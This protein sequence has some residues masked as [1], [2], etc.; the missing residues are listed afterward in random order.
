MIEIRIPKLGLTMENAVV[1]GW[2]VDEGAEVCHD[3]LLLTIETDKLTFDIP[4][5]A[6]GI[7]MRTAAQGDVCT[8][9]A[10]VGY[11]AGDREEY[12]RLRRRLPP[13]ATVPATAV[14][15]APLGMGALSAPR[16]AGG[17]IKASPLARAV[18]AERGLD[19]SRIEG[20]G[21][22]GRIVR[23]DILR[24]ADA[25]LPASGV[26]PSAD[27]DTRPV[28]RRI[29]ITGARRLLFESMH[30]SMADT[31]QFSLHTD[32]DAGALQD[33]R[34]RLKDEGLQISYNAMLIKITAAA[35]RKHP[36][37]NAGVV[38]GN[39]ILV[40][41]NVNIG[42]AMHIDGVLVVPVFRSADALSLRQINTRINACMRR[43]KR[44][45]LSPDELT[46]G[47]FTITN[48]GF[49]DVDH[50]T[51]I[52]RPPESAVLGVGRIVEKPVAAQGRIVVR[53]MVGL[54]LTVDHRIIDG[55]PAARF[56]HTLKQMLENPD[57][58]LQDSDVA[59]L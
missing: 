28:L 32:A 5:P 25:R 20:S 33:L 24:S 50:F 37:I 14:G 56:L 10:V 31:A 16:T 11:L 46:G 26:Q 4:A 12:R 9:E 40:W 17:R 36:D 51:P 59:D 45:R 29:P 30:R 2:H 7:L 38:W 55:A 21:P 57:A 41:K 6:G 53:P 22:G 54:S 58:V 3:D 49:T 23:A 1:A 13:S 34:G 8:V 42:L 18:A 39:E 47:T 15:A 43:I 48:L 27:A 35:L 52:L 44:K 19:L